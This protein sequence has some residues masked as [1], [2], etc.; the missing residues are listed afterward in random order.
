M[1]EFVV[2]VAVVMVEVEEN[3]MAAVIWCSV[4]L[5]RW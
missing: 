5:W 3:V 2:E 4:L 1:V